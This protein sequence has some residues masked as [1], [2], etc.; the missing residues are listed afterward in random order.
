MPVARFFLTLFGL[1]LLMLFQWGCEQGS[2]ER[3]NILLISLDTLR[4]DHLHC[5]GYDKNTSPAIDALASEGVLF[6]KVYAQSP[7]T[8][9]SHASMLSALYPSRHGVIRKDRRIP[10]K[11]ILLSE[12]LKENGYV[13][14]SFNGSSFVS[15]KFGFDQGFDLY[16]EIPIIEGNAKDIFDRFLHW[17]KGHHQE[18][19]FAFLHTY[20]IHRPYEP[21]ETYK[22][23]YVPM[24]K[25]T[26]PWA[27]RILNKI[28]ENRELTVEDYGFLKAMR[29]CRED[30]TLR[31]WIKRDKRAQE[32]LAGR[33]IENILAGILKDEKEAELEIFD[34]WHRL[35]LESPAFSYLIENYDAEVIF[36]DRQIARL[37]EALKVFELEKKTLIIITSD[38]G[39]EFTEH[40]SLGHGK[41][42]YEET[43]RVPLIFHYPGRLPEGLRI[44]DN[45][46]LIDLPPTV[47][48]L[49]D[50]DIPGFF[51]GIS[52]EPF[53]NGKAGKRRVIFSETLYERSSYRPVVAVDGDWKYHFDQRGL[54]PEELYHLGRDPGER[55]NL[56]KINSDVAQRL[57]REVNGYL[58]KTPE[59]EI[60]EV[61]EDGDIRK[62]LQRLGYVQDSP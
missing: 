7:W 56:V 60:E 17:L 40:G 11:I 43:I 1:F 9:P 37:L 38:H 42:C 46:A 54:R 19:F 36:S 14:A 45:A 21:P 20:E 47:L 16:E 58:E 15:S 44:E 39:E 49:A 57:N 29:F 10:D 23:K 35:D 32:A 31:N 53:F 50:L 13:T 12:I 18:T 4:A 51:D 28:L 22:Q 61:T 52:L 5:Y 25:I 41:T 6:E 3:P 26:R 27:D 59:A 33:K 30:E 8:L 34:H 24:E 2:G 48:G 55:V 62:Q